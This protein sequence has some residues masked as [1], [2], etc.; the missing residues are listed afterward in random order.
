[1]KTNDRISI[2]LAVVDNHLAHLVVQKIRTQFARL[3]L[4]INRVEDGQRAFDDFQ[5]RR[6]S[7]IICAG[8]LPHLSGANLAR[9]IRKRDGAVPIFYLKSATDQ[10]PEGVDP[11][12][13]PIVDWT[14]FLL[15][16]QASLP[17]DWKAKFGL[18]ERNSALYKRLVAFGEKY[19]ASSSERPNQEPLISIPRLFESEA[20]SEAS[21]KAV[22]EKPSEK[23]IVFK[24]ISK[25]QHRKVL[26]LEFSILAALTFATLGFHFWQSSVPE[27]MF[28]IK[29]LL[30]LIT[31]FSYFGF[32][33]GR[34]FDRYVISKKLIEKSEADV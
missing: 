20:S 32:F 8:D 25:E 30:T 10:A 29:R 27:T 3:P 2:L 19:H 5:N 14:D 16:V 1:M 17:D 22:A 26:T 24:E 23:K 34:A 4:E 13:V 21:P 28:S 18:F 33:T 12:A 15:K 7:M 6:A 11:I 31:V 9:E